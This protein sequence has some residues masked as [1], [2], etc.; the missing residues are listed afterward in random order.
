MDGDL[1]S[2]AGVSLRLTGHRESN[3]GLTAMSAARM[4]ASDGALTFWTIIAPLDDAAA[5]GRARIACLIH[6]AFMSDKNIFVGHKI[7]GSTPA[8]DRRDLG[9]AVRAPPR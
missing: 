9:G 5:N 7:A 3:T 8:H 4:P 1:L 6:R 2:P